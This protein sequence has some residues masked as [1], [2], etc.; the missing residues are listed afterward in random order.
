MLGISNRPCASCSSN[1]EITRAI[2]LCIVLH[3]VQLL[4][5]AFLLDSLNLIVTVYVKQ[6]KH[7][8][9]KEI[10]PLNHMVLT[11]KMKLSTC[12]LYKRSMY[13]SF[14]VTP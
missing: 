3:S 4:L 1:F 2:T 6:E 5:V 14:S 13:R 9:L 12:L 10:K 7:I 11:R 8:S